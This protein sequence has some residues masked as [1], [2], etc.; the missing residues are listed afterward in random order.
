MLFEYSIEKLANF[1]VL[2]QLAR[3]GA[4]RAIGRIDERRCMLLLQ[5]RR[6]CCRTLVSTIR[7]ALLGRAAGCEPIERFG[8]CSIERSPN[9]LE[10]RIKPL[11]RRLLAAF[12]AFYELNNLLECNRQTMDR[13]EF[14]CK[15]KLLEFFAQYLRKCS[16]WC[17]K[18]FHFEFVH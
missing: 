14:V 7:A 12:H 13:N 10:Q 9:N 15:H 3:C 1:F 2:L 17:H 16:T 8:A 4:R 11:I 5:R 18:E 6:R